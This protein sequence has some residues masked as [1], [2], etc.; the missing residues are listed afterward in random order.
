[1]QGGQT[2]KNYDFFSML[3]YLLA[4]YLVSILTV[5]GVDNSLGELIRTGELSNKLVKPFSYFWAAFFNQYGRKVYRLIYVA[6][7]LVLILVFSKL[8][9]PLSSFLVFLIIIVNATLLAYLFRFLLGVS[10]FWL[11]NI[12]SILWLFRNSANFLGGGWMPVDFFPAYMSRV[13]KNLP[14]YL[15]LGFPAEFFQNKINGQTALR[16]II[17][18]LIWI[19]GLFFIVGFLWRKGVKDYEAV[20]N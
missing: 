10:A 17:V 6:I 15:S 13:F 2:F 8:A 4:I 3:Q 18:Q 16:L 19:W 7:V 12:S 20:G 14:F 9:L 1:M 11:T 5:T